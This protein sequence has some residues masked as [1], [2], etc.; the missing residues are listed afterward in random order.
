MR[1]NGKKM[2]Y[3]KQIDV[4][5]QSYTKLAK[6]S[7]PHIDTVIIIVPIYKMIDTYLYYLINCNL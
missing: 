1:Q 5:L 4:M 7:I 3:K 2:F 6:T